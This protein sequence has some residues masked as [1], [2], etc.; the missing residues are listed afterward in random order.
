MVHHVDTFVFYDDVHFIN[1]GY[2]NRNNI[3]GDK[4]ALRFT[5]PLRGASQNK[6]INEIQLSFGEKERGKLLK[7]LK[8]QYQKAPEFSTVFPMLEAFIQ[9][10]DKPNISDLASESITLISNYLEISTDFKWSSTH[11]SD[12]LELKA[13]ERLIEIS[14]LLEATSYVNP[15]GGIELYNKNEF[16]EAGI[17]LFFL[18]PKIHE[19][20]Q[21][22]EAFIPNLSIIDVLMFNS[23]EQVQDM[24]NNYD[25]V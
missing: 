24:L 1:K 16:K 4:G 18:R 15:I 7:T 3:L 17:D 12:S 5:I 11:F 19:Y 10:F 6:K 14:K 23:K 9:E 21:F 2:I 20:T 25:L 22:N 8:H 13:A